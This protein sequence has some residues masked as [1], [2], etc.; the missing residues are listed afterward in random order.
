MNND[1]TPEPKKSRSKTASTH[2]TTAGT[3]GGDVEGGANTN[4]DPAP[5]TKKTHSKT[6]DTRKP[7]A[8]AI[9]GD[10]EGAANTRS[11]RGQRKR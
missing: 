4:D 2:K 5:K 9:G 3:S 8:D 7:T 1:P 6:A 11:G 10:V